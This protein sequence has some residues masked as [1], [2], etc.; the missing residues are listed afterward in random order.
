VPKRSRA[1]RPN[2]SGFTLVEMLITIV[3]LTVL[4]SIVVFGVAQFRGD[5]EST[6]CEADAKIVRSAASAYELQRGSYP[7][8]EAALVLTGYIK[9]PPPGVAYTFD[10][11]TKTVMQEACAL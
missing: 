11:G 5:S 2:D 6:A 7:A 8:D 1:V 9:D 3:V 10:Q 4:V